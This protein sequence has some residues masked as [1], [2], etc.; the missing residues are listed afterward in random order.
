MTLPPMAIREYRP[1]FLI[2]LLLAA[3]IFVIRNCANGAV[4]LARGR[5]SGSDAA[6]SI[7]FVWRTTEVRQAAAE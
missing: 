1:I 5:R 3:S 6:F 7:F 4:G 2:F